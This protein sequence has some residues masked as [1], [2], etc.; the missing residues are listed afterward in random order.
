MKHNVKLRAEDAEDLAIVAALL[1]DARISL[2]EMVF[3]PDE[4]RFLASFVRY[5]RELLDD[6]TSCDGLT[7]VQSVL[8]FTHVL[9]VKYREL[10]PQDADQELVLLTI[11]TEPGDAHLYYIDLVFQGDCEIQLRSDKIECRVVDFGEPRVSEV[12]PCDHA[13]L[14]DLLTN[15]GAS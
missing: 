3:Q 11:A 5:R 15:A 14:D 8:T 6:P 2:K 13:D 1:Q 9:N 10:D 12:T 7:E 4:N